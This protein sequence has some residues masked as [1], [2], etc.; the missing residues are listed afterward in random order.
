MTVASIETTFHDGAREKYSKQANAGSPTRT[1]WSRPVAADIV[2]L[3]DATAILLG[4]G[5]PATIHTTFG[6]LEIPATTIIRIALLVAVI[7]YLCLRNW[8]MYPTN[9]MHDFPVRPLALF[10]ALAI[11]MVAV[12]GIGLPF[13]QGNFFHAW[14]WSLS[15]FGASFLLL[16]ANRGLANVT[17]AWLTRSG[18]F[19]TRIAVFG[20][21]EVA[22][23]VHLHLRDSKL[24]I[25]LA[26][27]YDDRKDE[28]RR[29]DAGLEI[30]GRLDDLLRAG[31]SGEIDEIIIALPQAA[32]RRIAQIALSLE[33]LPVS[34]HIVT[35]ISSDFVSSSSA[36]KVSGLG[37]V[38]LLDVK[39]KPLSDWS[40][41]IK[42]I[43]D[44]GLGLI[45]LI[46]ALPLIGIIALLIK[47]ESS[48][49]V[50]FRQHRRGLN[51]KVIDVIK[52]RTMTVLENGPDIKQATENDPRITG[53]GW[54]LRRTS[55]DELPQLIN[56]LKGEMSIVGP[57]PHA[58]AH[59][60]A[61][62]QLMAQY[63]NRHQVKPG[64]TG[65]AQVRGLRGITHDNNSIEERVRNDLE[66]IAKWSLWLDIK[67]ICRTLVTIFNGRNAH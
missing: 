47:L 20:A 15:W 16:L 36:H 48:G 38:G 18:R 44:Y 40:P 54:W 56:V 32:A 10:S 37:S 27:V 39:S 64:I 45:F 52:F 41:L 22:H 65:L 49:P 23:R 14:I 51:Q 8:N 43:E 17:L 62:E 19:D 6:S 50:F 2:G 24:G 25:A 59:D 34:I 55:L 11:A 66:Y 28:D 5:V 67:I 35:H 21:G 33:Q 60:E 7:V 61:W 1:R 31:R 53:V 63:S 13:N 4:A 30:S 26:G 46:L 57:R 42:R 9:G 58:V 29:D 12:I 3:G